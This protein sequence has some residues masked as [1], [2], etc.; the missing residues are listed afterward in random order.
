MN[1]TWYRFFQACW[2][3]GGLATP[4]LSLYGLDHATVNVVA[5]AFWVSTLDSPPALEV[6]NLKSGAFVGKITM[7]V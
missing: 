5:P 2:Q 3:R 4:G 6:V 1:I 7:D